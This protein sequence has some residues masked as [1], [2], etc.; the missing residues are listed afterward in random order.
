MEK[1]RIHLSTLMG[2]KKVRSIHQLSKETGIS[3]PVLGKLYKEDL[4]YKPHVDTLTKLCD[5][6]ECPLEEL[7]EYDPRDN[8]QAI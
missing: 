7:I 3:R 2:K 5:Y 6:F 4:S 1:L 8:G